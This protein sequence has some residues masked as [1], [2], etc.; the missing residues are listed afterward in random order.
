MGCNGRGVP[1]I[2]HR[3]PLCCGCLQ[4]LPRHSA[5]RG[6]PW[7]L[8][9]GPSCPRDTHKRPRSHPAPKTAWRRARSASKCLGPVPGLGCAARPAPS[10]R[11]AP[12][13]MPTGARHLL[14]L[15]SR[16]TAEL[17]DSILSAQPNPPGLGTLAPHQGLGPAPSPAAARRANPRGGRA[18]GPPGCPRR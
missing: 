5:E 14:P 1:Q 10:L 2:R 16:G 15:R 9:A 7:P 17:A 11:A 6:E 4:A 13:A 12:S 8:A 18:A 3:H